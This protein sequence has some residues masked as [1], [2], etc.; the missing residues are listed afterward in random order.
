M[1][2]SLINFQLSVEIAR[3][4]GLKP[5]FTNVFLFI[6][7]VKCYIYILNLYVYVDFV[8]LSLVSIPF[9]ISIRPSRLYINVYILHTLTDTGTNLI[10]GG[11][12]ISEG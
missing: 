10:L 1:I 2:A 12:R 6:F 9:N 11:L 8:R 4:M 7:Y 3:L 5:H